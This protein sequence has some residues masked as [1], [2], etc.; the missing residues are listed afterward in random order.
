[1]GCASNL[2][3]SK[4]RCKSKLGEARFFASSDLA[5]S[6][7]SHVADLSQ[8]TYAAEWCFVWGTGCTKISILLF[9]RRLASGTYT[10][11]F[12]YAT[13]FGIVYNV[14]YMLGFSLG[15]IFLCSPTRAYWMAFSEEWLLTQH[16]YKCGHE[17]ISL[18][19]SGSFSVLGDAYS[20]LLPIL[21]IRHLQMSHKQK[22]ALYSLF[23][24]GFV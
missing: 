15:L 16:K 10:T 5:W 6:V 18:P 2:V 14:L 4:P 22:V 23:A 19:L 17:N 12:L 21:L 13:Y 3:Y 7:W 11:K 20:T 24:S 8:I 9:Y 1:M